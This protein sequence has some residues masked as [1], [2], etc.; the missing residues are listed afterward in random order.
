MTSQDKGMV[1]LALLTLGNCWLFAAMVFEYLSV[2][3]GM[4]ICGLWSFMIGYFGTR[5]LMGNE[6]PW[7]RPSYYRKD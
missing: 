5:W 4:G 3:M 6:R 7:R 1:L 2:P